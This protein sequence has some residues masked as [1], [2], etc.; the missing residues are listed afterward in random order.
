MRGDSGWSR[1]RARCVAAV[2]AGTGVLVASAAT[3]QMP[4]TPP[5][6]RV[7]VTAK[8]IHALVAAVMAGV[9]TPELLVD[10]TAS[11]HTYAMKPSDALKVHQADVLFRVSETLEPYTAKVL[12]SLPASVRVVTLA[13]VAGVTR[14]PRRTGTTFE[15]DGEGHGHGHA[16]D[17]AGTGTSAMGGYDPHVW[18]DPANAR[19]MASAIAV[20]L[21]LRRPVAADRLRANADELSL[22]IDRLSAEIARD[23][24]PVASRPFVV[25]HDATQYFE[26][27]FRLE[28]LGS[29]TL[30][31]DVQPSAKRLT[32]LRR[33]VKSL[34][35]A[36]VFAEPQQ[37]QKLIAGVIEGTGVRTGL[38]DPEGI[39]L[40]AGPELYFQL[41]RKLAADIKACLSPTA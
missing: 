19:A 7:V 24:A 27:R 3:A 34:A 13:E 2:I 29:I 10:G 8:P 30:A 12:Q 6:L 26:A 21:A 39:T 4:A 33:K 38:L 37:S 36:C 14:L 31:P 25:F 22:R 20:E 1:V 28:A 32:E 18:L 16:P 23:L 5:A 17:K 15:H 40:G 41:M 9:G 35:P 11:P